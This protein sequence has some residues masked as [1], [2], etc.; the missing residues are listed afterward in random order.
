[1]TRRAAMRTGLIGVPGFLGCRPSSPVA[2]TTLAVN[3]PAFFFS[4]GNWVGDDGRGG[5]VFRQTW[6]PGAYFRVTWESETDIPPTLLLDTSTYGPAFKAPR[7]A[8]CLDGILTGNVAC[9]QEITLA[10]ARPAGRHQLTVF[11]QCSSQVNRWGSP[12]ESGKNVLRVNGLRVAGGSEPLAEAAKTRWALIV[13]DSITEGIGANQ[14]EGYSH[15]FGEALLTQGYEYCI[16]ACGWSGWLNKGDHP[17]G[18]VPGYYVVRNSL[19]GREGEYF[20][21]ESRWDKI[22]ANNSLLDTNGRISAT[23]RTGEEPSLI[24]IN[25]GTNDALCQQ[26]PSDVQ[27]SIRQ[28]VDALR[29]AAPQAHLFVLIPFGQYKATE[30]KRAVSEFKAARPNDDRIT[31]ID[32]GPDVAR[33]LTPPKGFWGDLHPNPRAHAMLAARIIAQVQVALGRTPTGE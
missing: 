8:Y 27:A 16:S 23:G 10:G 9:T 4:P 32:L 24:L 12:G 7:L 17:P 19:N 20:P 3:S 31:L 21:S 28:A 33:A 18:D 25:Y 1:M 29:Q 22:D 2:T 30:L 6:N 11:L 14:L 15:L 13:G 5:L 26:N